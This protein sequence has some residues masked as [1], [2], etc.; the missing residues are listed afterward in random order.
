MMH[1]AMI[2]LCLVMGLGCGSPPPTFTP[3]FAVTFITESD[4]GVPLAGVEV[5]ANGESQGVS[6]DSGLLQ[7]I[8]RGEEGA[9]VEISY[10]CPET[11]RDAEEVETL[12]LA[13]FE[14]LDPSESNGLQKR[15]RCAPR[16]RRAAFVV[17]TNGQVGIPVFLGGRQ[18]TRTNQ[19]GVAYFA[20]RSRPE[21]EFQIKLGTDDNPNLRPQNPTM[22]FNL[23]DGDEVF[24]FDQQFEVRNTTM[25]AARRRPSRSRIRRIRRL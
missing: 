8:L 18:V 23:G 24:V 15:L 11:H 10:R 21:E 19:R 4:P 7:S 13:R 5:F 2:G 25:R 3:T 6:G 1:R 22:T 17:R 9:A 16:Q 12:R 14:G 20:L